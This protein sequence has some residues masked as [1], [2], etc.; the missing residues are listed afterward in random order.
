MIGPVHKY[1]YFYTKNDKHPGRHNYKT[2]G[3]IGGGE[4]TYS[5]QM[6]N[7]LNDLYIEVKI[8]YNKEENCYEWYVL[9]KK[10]NINNHLIKNEDY[11]IT[12]NLYEPIVNYKTN[13]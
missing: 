12:F 8:R 7:L 10:D 5:E 3:Y 4:G 9:D 11:E 2:K 13:N 6:N 1:L